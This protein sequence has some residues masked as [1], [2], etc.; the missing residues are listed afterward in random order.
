[1]PQAINAWNQSHAKI[2]MAYIVYQLPSAPP[3]PLKMNP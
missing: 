3:A 2:E 1:V